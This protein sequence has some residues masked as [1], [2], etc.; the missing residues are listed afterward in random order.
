MERLDCDLLV[1]W[2]GARAGARVIHAR[3]SA[4]VIHARAGARVIHARAGARV[5]HP[6]SAIAYD[7]I[8]LHKLI[9]AATSCCPHRTPER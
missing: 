9:G 2:F 6:R 5:I 7:L 4:R 3:A 8:G 1:L